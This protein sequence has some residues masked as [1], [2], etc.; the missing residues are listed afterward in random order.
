MG[1]GGNKIGRK[2]F[3][4]KIGRMVFPNSCLY[5]VSSVAKFFCHGGHGIKGRNYE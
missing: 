2:F 5:S 1:K 3:G 4:R